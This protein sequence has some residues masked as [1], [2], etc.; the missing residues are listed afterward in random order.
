MPFF[1][2]YSNSLLLQ[3]KK[4]IISGA[5]TF[6]DGNGANIFTVPT[7]VSKIHAVAV[8]GGGTGKGARGT[9]HAGGGG[10]GLG[11]VNDRS[12][13]AGQQLLV[14]AGHGGNAS[15]CSTTNWERAIYEEAYGQDSFIGTLDATITNCSA[16]NT[17]TPITADISVNCTSTTGLTSGM[18]VVVGS[19][20][21]KLQNRTTVV[22]VT[23][24]TAFIISAVPIR[25]LSAATIY[26]SSNVFVS[27]YGG[28]YADGFNSASGISSSSYVN[29]LGG[30]GGSYIGDGGGNGGTGGDV[31]YY[32]N[33]STT[34]GGS[35]G[36]GGGA[37]GYSGNGGNGGRS[38][39]S[40][41]SAPVAGSS[42]SGGGGG[43][44]CGS[45]WGPVSSGYS[46]IVGSHGGSVGLYGRTTGAAAGGTLYGQGPGQ[47][48]IGGSGGGISN[49]NIVIS[50]TYSGATFS[51][52]LSNRNVTA[53]STPNFSV[54]KAGWSAAG[55]TSTP[56]STSDMWLSTKSTSTSG[57]MSFQYASSGTGSTTGDIRYWHSGRV[58]DETDLLYGAGSAGGSSVNGGRGAVR[59]IWGS[60]RAFPNTNV[61]TD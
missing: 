49:N 1:S 32:F 28:K 6:L 25:T 52:S 33:D 58:Q 13:T 40:N 24:S 20:S 19:G 35:G 53:S 29:F 37:G 54:I 2:R 59:I 55:L 27:G 46:T 39:N 16:A 9:Q 56:F 7:G 30:V 21:G 11:W 12:V 26:A 51:G 36:G 22:S 44:G 5:N 10:G 41:A 8:G 23:N 57:T 42:G 31:G 47:S 15:V 18:R 3:Q 38:N 17:A 48:G 34:Y 50:T 60:G 61:S 4:S 14:Y 43:G 45:Y